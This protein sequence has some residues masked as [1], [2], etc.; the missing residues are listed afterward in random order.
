MSVERL[1]AYLQN[2]TGDSLRAVVE[3]DADAFE[4]YYLRDDIE[5]KAFRQRVQHAHDGIMQRHARETSAEAFGDAYATLSI[6]EYA[7]IMNLRWTPTEGI[8][9]GLEPEVA[10]DL[11]NFVHES[12][13]HGHPEE[14]SETQDSA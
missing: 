12:L 10:R 5:P 14:S 1:T 6:R 13:E 11:V 2:R 7:V 4:I 8:L 3:Y 9:V